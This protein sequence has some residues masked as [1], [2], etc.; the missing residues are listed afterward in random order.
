MEQ[1][2]EQMLEHLA[3]DGWSTPRI[4]TRERGFTASAGRIRDRFQRLQYVGFVAP[5]H[6]DMYEIT[7]W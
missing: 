2:D 7:Q 5:P 4:M 6:Q 3:A 1:I